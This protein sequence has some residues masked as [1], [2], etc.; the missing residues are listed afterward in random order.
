[1]TGHKH[2][3]LI[4]AFAVEA[5]TSET[6]WDIFESSETVGVDVWGICTKEPYWESEY[7]R[8]RLKPILKVIDWSKVN[9]D[10]VPVKDE[11]IGSVYYS[12]PLG[13]PEGITL[14]TGKR[15]AWNSGECPLPEGVIVEM[16]LRNGTVGSIEA[17]KL[18][19]TEMGNILWFRVTGLVHGYSWG[20]V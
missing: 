19:W 11:E 2:A 1:M 17:V 13:A 3:D 8:F 15:I 9:Y 7:A 12:E 10:I 4:T 16:E 6:P 18:A 14:V 20:E 5:Q